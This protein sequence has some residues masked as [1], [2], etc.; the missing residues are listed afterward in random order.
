MQA[1]KHESYLDCDLV[2][3]V[4]ERALRNQRIGHYFFWHLR[5]EMQ[6]PSMQTRFGLL[7][8]AYLK[9]CK[10]HVPLLRK[11]L[12]CLE[13]LKLSSELAKKGSKEKVRILL[14][15][16]LSNQ[17]N[18]GVFQSIQNPLNPS[19]RCNGVK[20]DKC[21]VMDSKMRPLWI[22]FENADNNCNDIYIIF[23][24]G[25]DLRQDMLTLQMLRVMDQL[26]KNE[27]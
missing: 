13:K 17:R 8:E 18:S 25:D 26:W 5:S 23:K 20:P 22:V 7:L 10:P 11:Q 21:K 24:N 19:F 2:S 12:Q 1:I 4:L 15:D 3:F 14:H 16:F 27:G 9:G 6:T